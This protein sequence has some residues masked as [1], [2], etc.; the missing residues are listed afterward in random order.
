VKARPQGAVPTVDVHDE[1]TDPGIRIPAQAPAPSTGNA[2]TSGTGRVIA[3][4]MGSLGLLEDFLKDPGVSEIMVNDTRNIMVER[5]GRLQSSGAHFSSLEELER[6]VRALLESTGRILS[7]DTPYLDVLLPDGSRA[8]IVGP[9][10]TLGG[11]CITI[12][13]FPAHTL[14]AE[15]LIEEAT[16]D[17][18]AAQF[19]KACVLSRFNVIVSGGTGSGKTTLLNVLTSFVPRTERI[20]T[21]ED[22]PELRFPHTNSVRLQSKPQTVGS[23][24]ITARELVAN[25][26]RMRPDRILVG[27]CRK[28]EAF[29]ML[30]A[31]NTGHAGSMTTLHANSARDALSRLETL[32]LQAG[33]NLPLL[34]IRKQIASAVDFIVQIERMK[35]GDRKVTSIAELTGMEGETILMQEVF[36]F[37]AVKYE[38]RPAGFLPKRFEQI[39]ASGI[40]IPSDFFSE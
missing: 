25:A 22:V 37:D 5:E 10:V 16:L 14:T 29:D 7:P 26:L 30:Q 2:Q 36:E 1:K 32:C 21:I 40:E 38:L 11:P 13:K 35:D 4:R 12:R 27:E 9:P 33:V 15:K 28:G 17:L 31:M 18:K 34:N 23:P 20:V 3:P 19:L 8:N 24:P 6:I 39:R